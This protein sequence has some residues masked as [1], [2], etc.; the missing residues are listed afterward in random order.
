VTGIPATREMTQR[1]RDVLGGFA[2][3]GG[4]VQSGHLLAPVMSGRA[5]LCVPVTGRGEL[6]AGR[7]G[8]PLSSLAAQPAPICVVLPRAV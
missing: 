5:N 6:D 3:R 2:L 1:L 4:Q 8:N 7:T